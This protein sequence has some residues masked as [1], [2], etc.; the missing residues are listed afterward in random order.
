MCQI[1]S[2][3]SRDKLVITNECSVSL[4][5]R[6]GRRA[7]AAAL[8]L[9]RTAHVD[10]AAYILV[11]LEDDD[12]DLGRVEANQGDGRVQTDRHAEGRD[13]HLVGVSGTEVDRHESEPDDAR[14]VHGEA[15]ELALVEVLR[16]L[17]RLYRVYSR[18]EDQ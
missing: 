11:R 12:I 10:F 1:I 13:L 18:N 17:A 15:D 14:G 3:R 2:S 5:F 4:T 7:G 6:H 16:D 8:L 9:E